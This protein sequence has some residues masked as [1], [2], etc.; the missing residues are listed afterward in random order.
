MD[1]TLF[2]PLAQY[3]S[4][5]NAIKANSE[6]YFE[7]LRKDAGVDAKENEKI[8]GNYYKL[9]AQIEK[10]KKHR[11]SLR[12]WRVFFYIFAGL[13]FLLSIMFLIFVFT[14]PSLSWWISIFLLVLFA[15]IG[16]FLIVAAIKVLTPKIRNFLEQLNVM[17]DQAST[18]LEEATNQMAPLNERYDWNSQVEI[19]RKT[20]PLLSLDKTFDNKKQDM[21]LHRFHYDENNQDYSSVYFAQSGTIRD[22][23]FIIER[24]YIVSMVNQTYTGATTIHWTTTRTN[25]DGSVEKINH[26]QTLT[27]SVSRPR[28]VYGYN[29]YLFYGNDSCPNLSFLRT[30]THLNNPTPQQLS[31]FVKYRKKELKEKAKESL[32]KSQQAAFTSLGDEDFDA[33]FGAFDRNN[34]VEFRVLFTPLAEKGMT[35]IITK[36]PFGDDFSFSKSG[37]L[38][39]VRSE[40][41]ETSNIYANPAQFANFDLAL[42]K[43]NFIDYQ[44][45]YFKDLYFAIAPILAIP[46]YEN[47]KPTGF[48]YEKAKTNLTDTEE[49]V[50]ANSYSS[51]VFS[52]PAS[53]TN[54]ILKSEF[55]ESVGPFDLTEISAHSYGA[56]HLT[57]TFVMKGQDGRLHDV[58]VNYIEYFP[59][60]QKTHLYLINLG[61]SRYEYTHSFLASQ[62]GRWIASHALEGQSLSFQRGILAF[63]PKHDF[64]LEEAKQYLALPTSLKK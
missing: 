17:Q 1:E 13:F 11:N 7:A 12:T 27:A 29:T 48:T 56:N 55:L 59:L 10:K 47:N 37:V 45:N 50:L 28:P 53:A 35:N 14:I 6:S 46:E 38:N 34:E 4:L 42:A 62:R 36:S 33:L 57:Q 22:N 30:P 9:L 19:I 39:L 63:I 58:N 60:L 51:P 15:L 43:K 2:D 49:E 8:V 44:C 31:K 40:H 24:D 41:L 52:A 16:A 26:E 21:F 3:P 18:L 25:K 54:T 64:S 5:A 20:V 32:L 23:P 61:I